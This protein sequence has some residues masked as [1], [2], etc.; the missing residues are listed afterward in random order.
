VSSTA[1][2]LVAE[3]S[4][5]LQALD[6]LLPPWARV[7]DGLVLTAAGENTK[8]AGILLR[9]THPPGSMARMWSAAH[10]SELVPVLG[11]TGLAGMDALLTVWR[12]RLPDL[13]LPRDDSAC[14]VSW[15]SRDAETGRA[16]LDH[17]LVPL[18]VIAVRS[19]SESPRRPVPDGLEIR[20]A[21]PR[22]LEDCL[23]LAMVEQSYSAMMGGAVPRA[24]TAAL[25]RSLLK[26]RLAGNEPIWLADMSG[27]TVG[28]LECG[29]NDA[30][31]GTWTA[32]RLLPGRWGYVNCA[33]VQPSAR[34][35]GVG[36]ALADQA[37]ATFDAAGT[38]GSY[39][40]Y[41][42]PNPLSSVFWPR[43]GYRPLWTI[44]EARPACALR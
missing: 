21:E 5:R 12:S 2:R 35:R 30:S 1:E 43:Q 26:A 44:W 32:T 28:L 37:H 3:Q 16:L 22:D 36:R 11:A 9:F 20:R 4:R 14:V 24:G 29:Y 39:L 18:S 15:P 6:P 38:V 42:P 34:D 7:P 19:A 8:V 41:N 23:R 40:Y 10:V 17:G 25:K 13:S 31:P 33:S 27:V